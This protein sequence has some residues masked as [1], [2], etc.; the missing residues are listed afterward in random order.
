MGEGIHADFDGCDHAGLLRECEGR[1]GLW[2]FRDS[3]CPA[4]TRLPVY[5]APRLRGPQHFQ[6]SVSPAFASR[7][8]RS[9][10]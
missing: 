6:A 10:L 3:H 2:G 1:T 5:E 8:L 4:F 9:S 7:D